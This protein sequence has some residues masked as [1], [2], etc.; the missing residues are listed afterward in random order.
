MGSDAEDVKPLKREVFLLSLVAAVCVVALVRSAVVVGP[1][2]QQHTPAVPATA[3]SV[4]EARWAQLEAAVLDA[5][6]QSDRPGSTEASAPN[7]AADATLIATAVE[8][9]EA[10]GRGKGK[11][12]AVEPEADFVE[13]EPRAEAQE[14]QQEET[15]DESAE[16]PADQQG[17]ENMDTLTRMMYWK[18]GKDDN[19]L[20]TSKV[21][22]SLLKNKTLIKK[23]TVMSADMRL[24]YRCCRV[25]C[26]R[27]LIIHGF[28][29]PAQANTLSSHP[30]PAA[31]TT[32]GCPLRFR[33][34]SQHLPAEHWCFRINAHG[35]F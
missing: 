21:A 9:V 14:E 15:S 26:A 11:R 24:K 32:Y 19:A 13:E 31:S 25:S 8:S 16:Q 17:T 1:A 22:P 12:A 23:H 27:R 18:H 34:L 20:R 7:D 30:M 6:K 2:S 5:P 33:S 10:M 3:D 28:R 35:T 29:R 4:R